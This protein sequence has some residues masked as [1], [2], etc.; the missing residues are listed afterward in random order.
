[1]AFG[2]TV[3]LTGESEYRKALSG[4]T[5]NLKVLNS[6]MR[7]V[8][9][10]YDKNDKSTENLAQQ[11]EVLNRQIEE[12]RKRVGVLTEAL[13]QAEAETGENS[14]TSKK[15]RT[16][17]NNAQAQLN[18]LE[19]Q[20]GENEKTMQENADATEENAENIK[21]FGKEADDSGKKAL[22]LGDIIKP[23]S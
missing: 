3:K 22:S 4:I 12:Q 20:L 9:S 14:E 10:Q 17:L 23:T 13:A 16:E 11:N 1:M 18:G 5:N 21:K 2:G 15:W 19:R 8:T 7:V 6:E